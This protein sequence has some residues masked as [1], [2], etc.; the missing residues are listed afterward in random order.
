MQQTRRKIGGAEAAREEMPKLRS[1]LLRISI[2][3]IQGF[4][5]FRPTNHARRS[6]RG[7]DETNIHDNE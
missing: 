1:R 7:D 2:A 6:R 5:R 3:R 4:G